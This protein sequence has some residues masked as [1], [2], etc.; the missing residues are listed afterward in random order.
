[1]N[2]PK[3]LIIS[4]YDQGSHPANAPTYEEISKITSKSIISYCEANNYSYLITD[5]FDRSRAASWGKIDL[6][7]KHLQDFDYL[8]T[9]DSDLMIM[10]QNIK[11]ESIIDHDH[12]VFFTCYYHD[13]NHLNTG[14]IIYRN[15]PWTQNFLKEIW[16]D[17]EFVAA[18]PNCFFEQSGIVKWYKNHPEEQNHFKFLPVRS[19]NAHYH[20][21]M[22][23]LNINY[24]KGDLAVH[25]AGTDNFYRI[26][27]FKEFEKFITTKGKDVQ[28]FDIKIWD[29]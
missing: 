9:F 24:E 22:E 7:R 29:K 4:V 26:E 18:R 10:N 27:A 15:T 1:M 2:N 11:L 6:A 23:N 3:F 14:S 12:D 13:I 25:L 17:Q 19:I 21:G 5:E 8:W 16:E 28:K 20:L